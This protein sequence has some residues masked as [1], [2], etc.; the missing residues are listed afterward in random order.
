MDLE[1]PLL[2]WKV[3]RVC[4]SEAKQA[5]EIVSQTII[6]IF[7][8]ENSSVDGQLVVSISC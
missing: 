8:V 4:C 5:V 3:G 2:D 1:R 7:F 6:Y